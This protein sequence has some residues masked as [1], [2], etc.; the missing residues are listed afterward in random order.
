[1]PFVTSRDQIRE[2]CKRALAVVGV[3]QP[4]AALSDQVVRGPA[5]RRL[6]RIYVEDFSAYVTH[7]EKILRKFPEPALQRVQPMFH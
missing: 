3:D 7:D 5:K 1:V 2:F 6:G 4:F